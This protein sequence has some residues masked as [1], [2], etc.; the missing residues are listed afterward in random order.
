MKTFTS[1]VY[2]NSK[3]FVSF[4]KED[5]FYEIPTPMEYLMECEPEKLE[6]WS[7][8]PGK[9]Y[10]HKLWRFG[11]TET[12]IKWSELHKKIVTWKLYGTVKAEYDGRLCESSVKVAILQA[13]KNGERE[14]KVYPKSNANKPA[15]L[16]LVYVK[17]FQFKEAV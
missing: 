4:K 8:L 17:D 15:H 2:K 9:K 12:F 7:H 5:D 16:W 10:R 14:F 11:K 13:L 6:R 1:E 3:G